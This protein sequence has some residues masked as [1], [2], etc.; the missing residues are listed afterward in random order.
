[1]YD[2]LPWMCMCSTCGER[3]QRDTEEKEVEEENRNESPRWWPIMWCWELKWEQR[4]SSQPEK[5]NALQR[6]TVNLSTQILPPF[7]LVE[8]SGF[9]NNWK[10]SEGGGGGSANTKSVIFEHWDHQFDAQINHK[11]CWEPLSP[12]ISAW[13]FHFYQSGSVNSVVNKNSQCLSHCFS[14]LV[15][16]EPWRE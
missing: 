7:C 3:R 16:L 1:M 10:Q 11:R 8:E 2:F 15:A 12:A 4:S 14:C 13:V 5:W 9:R 6:D